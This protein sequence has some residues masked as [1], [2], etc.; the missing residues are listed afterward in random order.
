LGHTFRSFSTKNDFPNIKITQLDN[1]LK[2]ASLPSIG[3]SQ[4]ATVGLWL[5]AGTIYEK[6]RN[7]GVAYFLKTLAL[8]GTKKHTSQE[9]ENLIDNIGGQL[10]GYSS[11]ERTVYYVRSLK[12]DATK[13]VS[14]LG[15]ILQTNNYSQEKIESTRKQVLDDI[16]QVEKNEQDL[17]FD[18]LHSTAYSG[19]PLALPVVGLTDSVSTIKEE[20][21]LEFKNKYYKPD[22]TVL[23]GVGVDHDT[24]IKAAKDAGL[25]SLPKS[26]HSKHTYDTR[27]SG[28]EVRFR[29]D[30]IHLAHVAIGFQGVGT[31]SPDYFSLQI[32]QQLI[33]SWHQ[34]SGG[35]SEISSRL[36][37]IVTQ[38]GRP[39]LGF[40]AF[41][42]SYKDT[43]LF[44]V[45]FV[46]D[47][48]RLD[49]MIF[50]IEDSYVRLVVGV[51]DE[52]VLRARNQVKTNFLNNIN[53][54]FALSDDIGRQ[55]LSSGTYISPQ[56]FL[57]KLDMVDANTVRKVGKDHMY[58][59]DPVVA[60]LGKTGAMPDYNRIRGWTYWLRA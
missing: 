24:L 14:F 34:T 43:G 41:T 28:S 3:V 52:Q 42:T 19:T 5:D 31:N 47:G 23:V 45:Y 27:Y 58:D 49:D 13:S 22:G 29:D 51:K 32:L 4:T 38:E 48:K 21:I 15:E 2:V 60:S 6:E 56:E 26:H 55:L 59:T 33:G 39:A 9:L 30:D 50:M 18:Y 11:R 57:K 20:D 54:S 35:D 8:K 17:L 44:G 7:S 40:S 1:G 53:N 10:S 12:E 16:K 46:S 37:Q 25:A 36:A